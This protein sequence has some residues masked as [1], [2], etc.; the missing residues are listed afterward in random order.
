MKIWV[1]KYFK[2]KQYIFGS[3]SHGFMLSVINGK[4]Q[5][6]TFLFN[7]YREGKEPVVSVQSGGKL[8]PGKLNE[9][10]ITFDQKNFSIKLNN[11]SGKSVS[12]SGYQMR[13]KSG[14]IGC[15]EGRKNYF[16]GKIKELSITTL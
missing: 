7:R 3:G 2:E 16:T 12:I 10:E 4:L 15:G 13:P 9:L 14:V 1:D 11:V 6:E 5:A 8:I